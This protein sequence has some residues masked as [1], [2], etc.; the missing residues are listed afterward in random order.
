[1]RARGFLLGGDRRPHD[2]ERRRPAARGRP[3]PRRW[4]RPFPTASPTTRPSPTNSRSS[5]RTACAAC[6]RSR[7]TSSTTSPLMN[8]NYAQP[9]MPTGAEDGI[10]KGMYLLQQGGEA[11]APRVQ[12]LGSGTILREV[13]AAAELLE[14]RLGVV[15]RRLERDR[16]SPNCAREALDVRALEHAASRPSR[17]ARSHVEKCLADR[18]G[19]V[20]AAP[21]TS[22]LSPT[23]FAPSCP[24]RY[25]VLGT[26]GFGRSDYARD[27][28]RA[29]SRSIATTSRSRRSRR[30]PTRSRCRRRRVAAAIKKYG[31]D[32]EK[33]NPLTV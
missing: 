14:E 4:R 26:D 17:R 2:A 29:S 9:A 5:C 21:T 12:L 3:Q 8:E 31:I 24:K 28:A 32:P 13:I 15:G 33:P 22:R 18:P 27:A 19:P 30:W 7:R 25:V 6:S 1:M 20:V 10:I 11:K 16:A 23:R